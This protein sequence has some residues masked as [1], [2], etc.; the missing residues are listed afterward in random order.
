MQAEATVGLSVFEIAE[1]SL[2]VTEYR[3]AGAFAAFARRLPA[4][5]LAISPNLDGSKATSVFLRSLFPRCSSRSSHPFVLSRLKDSES[6]RWLGLDNWDAISG[7]ES[8][9][10]PSLRSIA[11]AVCRAA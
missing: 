2:Q 6:G 11:L 8:G 3:L 5:V 9:N 4:K 7:P 1:L 10:T